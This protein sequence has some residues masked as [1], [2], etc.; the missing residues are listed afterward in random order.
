MLGEVNKFAMDGI[1]WNNKQ[2][3]KKLKMNLVNK[4]VINDS[5]K[6]L[7]IATERRSE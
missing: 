4:F 3:P 2:H 7:L 1:E 6:R 5:G